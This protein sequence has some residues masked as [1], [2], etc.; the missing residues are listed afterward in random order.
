MEI[1]KRTTWNEKMKVMYM[2]LKQD[3]INRKKLKTVVNSEK[4]KL[5]KEKRI[6]RN[7][8]NISNWENEV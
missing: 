6:L 7:T 2:E 4:I 5:I 3:E 8:L 1:Q